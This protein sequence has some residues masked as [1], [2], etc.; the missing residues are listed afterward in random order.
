MSLA[1]HI[2]KLHKTYNNELEALRGIDLSIE[3]GNFFGLL[4]PNGAG[5]S[6][7]IGIIS[8]LVTKTSGKVTING[9]DL[10]TQRIQAKMQLGIVPQEFNFNIFEPCLQ[11]VIQQAGYYG[12]PYKEAKKRALALFEKLELLDKVNSPSGR[13]SGGLKRRLMIARALVHNPSILILDE[14]TAGV[15]VSLRRS[16]WTF[17]EELNKKEGITII[18]TTHYL[19]EAENLCKNIAIID[20]GSIISNTST[21]D[22]LKQVSS[23]SFV[24]YCSSF[25]QLPVIEGVSYTPLDENSTE[26][27]LQQHNTLTD[28][29]KQFELQGITVSRIKNKTNRLEELFMKMVKS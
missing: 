2:E 6:T 18:L 22:L 24:F 14:P 20:K 28:I 16:M 7:T 15:D 17:L 5:K 1:I 8:S 29:L 11:I 26:V 23:E 3:K 10:D 27:H 25:S 12:V 9:F 21:P 19:E 13:L 4:G